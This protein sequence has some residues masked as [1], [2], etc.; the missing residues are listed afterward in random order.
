MRTISSKTSLG[1]LSAL[2]ATPLV[3]MA[4]PSAQAAGGF[5]DAFAPSNWELSIYAPVPVPAPPTTEAPTTPTDTP[6]TTVPYTTYLCN[7]G[8]LN[9]VDQLD[10]NA[11][12]ATLI[13]SDFESPVRAGNPNEPTATQ[14]E[15]KPYTGPSPY[16]FTFKWSYFTGDTNAD[17]QSYYYLVDPSNT[18]T[19]TLL[20]SKPSGDSGLESVTLLSGWRLGFG[21]HTNDNSG[22]PGYLTITEFNPVSVVPGP[23]PLLGAGAAFGWSR[24]LRRRLATNL[25][26]SDR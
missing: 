22:G 2:S 7:P 8:D 20:S 25:K 3:L 4:A 11:G 17:D 19:T 24:R 23:L 10:A 5:T 21:V 9:C 16:A 18:V 26:T 15:L 6:D 14:W 1:L 12:T 13:G